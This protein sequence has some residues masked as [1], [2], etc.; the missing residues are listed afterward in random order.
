MEDEP[1]PE[2][3]RARRAEASRLQ[4]GP[5]RESRPKQGGGPWRWPR[6]GW[7]LDVWRARWGQG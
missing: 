3:G 4:G 5:R 6:A 1:E 7:S 2:G